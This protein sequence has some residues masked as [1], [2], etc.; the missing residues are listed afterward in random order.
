[1]VS[2]AAFPMSRQYSI[3]ELDKTNVES[4][5]R[6]ITKVEISNCPIIEFIPSELFNEVNNDTK[7]FFSRILVKDSYIP[8][9]RFELFSE[10]FSR[11]RIVKL[12]GN[13]ITDIQENALYALTELDSIDLSNND[14]KQINHRV[15]KNNQRLSSIDLS[16]NKIRLI[17]CQLFD[18]LYKLYEVKFEGNPIL[19][20]NFRKTNDAWE[21]MKE[22]LK[23]LFDHE[24]STV[25]LLEMVCKLI[26]SFKNIINDK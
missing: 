23:P 20:K 8:T 25:E 13:K 3:Y 17:H 4:S 18:G 16:N 2:S 15:F 24:N 10:K 12:S 5:L 21:A 22:E 19:D 1:M 11:L 7:N 6:F 14:I 26:Q 9:V